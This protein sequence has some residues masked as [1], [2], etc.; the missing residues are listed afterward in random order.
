MYPPRGRRS[1][2]SRGSRYCCSRRRRAPC[3]W[4]AALPY[5]RSDR[6]RGCQRRT[7]YTDSWKS[8]DGLILD[9]YRHHR[10]HHQANEFARGTNHI[11]GIE[12]FWAYAKHR[13]IKLKGIRKDKFHLLLKESEFR[14]NHRHDNLYSILLSNIR[15]NPLN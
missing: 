6:W 11:N 9:G 14:F 15:L 13:M 8:Y 2:H 4:P 1:R 5:V 12:S 3:R 10:V 7:L